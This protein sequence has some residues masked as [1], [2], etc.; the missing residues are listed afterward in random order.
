MPS[1]SNKILFHSRYQPYDR[2]KG[3]ERGMNVIL[4]TEESELC[5]FLTLVTQNMKE[6]SPELP[7]V[8]LRIAGGWVRDKLL[9]YECNDLDIAINS[10][11]GC[12]FGEHV[13]NFLRLK[14][15]AAENIHKIESNPEK[16]KHLETATTKIFGREVDFVNLRSEEYVEDS[17]I[18]SKV[19]F[20]TPE[21][22]AYRRDLTVNAL[23]YNIHTRKVE[24]PTK[25]G[26]VDL[27]EGLIRTPLDPYETFK[28]DP[29]RVLRCIRFASRFD[30]S[31]DE[32]ILV[33]VKNEQIKN[34]ISAKVS[35]ERIGIE[36]DKMIKGPHP[37]LAIKLIYEMNLYDT[38]FAP[39]QDYL[40]TLDNPKIAVC[41]AKILEWLLLTSNENHLH[42]NLSSRTPEDIR[43][44][45]LASFLAPHKTI[46]IPSKKKNHTSFHH[47]IK[48]SLKLK[49]S[50]GDITNKLFSF[51]DQ[52][53]TV[54]NQNLFTP[55]DRKSLGLLI[56]DIG[57]QWYNAFILALIC[58]LLPKYPDIESGILNESYKIIEKYNKLVDLIIDLELQN[59][60]N[61]KPIINGKEIACLLSLKQGIIIGEIQKSVIEWQLENPGG[62]KGQCE[63]YIKNKYR[64]VKSS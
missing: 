21:Q 40:G 23:F 12:E 3:S 10:M 54:A 57:S 15:Y 51:I 48:E 13:Y 29:L 14:G 30:F 6:N 18:P 53:T 24:D 16:S 56:R 20:G 47:V 64:D 60:F 45:Y 49:G 5:N 38:I 28:D 32:K 50:D 1:D 43:F 25:K 17:R 33:A 22:D 7:S 52:I 26:I 39:P 37:A 27:K 34:A 2:R 46:E 8:E 36:V 63:E 4:T 11:T 58:E 35:R 55:S 42:V 19:T 44:L 31:I 41:L 59:C 62:S 9:G 61:D